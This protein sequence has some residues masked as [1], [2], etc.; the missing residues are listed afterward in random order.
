MCRK[1][2]MTGGLGGR[3]Y[4]CHHCA[5]IS[6]SH[7]CPPRPTC[8]VCR[9]PESRALPTIPWICLENRPVTIWYPENVTAT[10]PE[11]KC[12]YPFFAVLTKMRSV[13]DSKS[14]G[15]KAKG[16]S[17]SRHRSRQLGASKKLHSPARRCLGMGIDSAAN[18]AGES[19]RT[20]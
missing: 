5:S 17:R 2:D 19:Q 10:W 12:L 3:P 14:I 15:V 1:M 20:G 7:H 4:W 6:S 11:N 18:L 13:S 9:R 8:P 16:L